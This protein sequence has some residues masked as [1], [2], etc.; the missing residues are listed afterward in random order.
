MKTTAQRRIE[1][2]LSRLRESNG[3]MAREDVCFL[4]V[5]ARQLVEASGTGSDF[6][7]VSFFADWTVHSRLDRNRGGFAV[8]QEITRILARNWSR[9]QEDVVTGVSKV[10]GFGRLR[11]EMLALFRG[12]DLPTVLFEAH[13]NW[14]SV[15]GFL[16]WHLEGQ[17]IAFPEKPTGWIGQAKASL[18][19]LSRP[20]DLA[21]DSLEIVRHENRPHWLLQ[22]SGSKRFRIMGPMEL[23]ANTL[24]GHGDGTGS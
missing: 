4:M 12:F 13:E 2:W 5:Q 8:L 11:R 19:A 22:V 24:A 21:V 1:D 7:V 16:L 20:R 17:P 23:S 18:L 14:L 10:I 3:Q 6:S 15:C 9:G